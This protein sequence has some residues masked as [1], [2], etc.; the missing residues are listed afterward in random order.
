MKNP[1]LDLT[2]KVCHSCESTLDR[3]I[4]AQSEKCTNPVCLIYNIT[5]SIPYKEVKDEKTTNT[6]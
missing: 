3:D 4:K 2:R 5:F 1:E 6:I